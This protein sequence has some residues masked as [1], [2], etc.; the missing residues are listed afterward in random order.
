MSRL[1]EQ[2]T[3]QFHQWELR[4]RG[5]QMFDEPVSPEPPFRPFHG[6]YLPGAPAIDDGR[7]ATFL[8]SLVQKL[9]GKLSTE[10][11]LASVESEPE[12]E[13]EPQSLVR[14]ELIEFQASLPD[15]L[16]IHKEAFEQFLLSLS[17]CREPIAFEL[18][19]K[20]NK[21]TAQ[22]AAAAYDAP[23]LRRQLQAHFPDAQ[24]REQEGTLEKAW[25]A[26]DGNEA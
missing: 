9:S 22:F 25:L 3:E 18:L 14:E 17:L 15:K 7:K 19:G 2:L 4:G 1:D 21:V 24:F 23:L 5:W 11:P 20:P 6:H 8:S 26:S 16:D 10:T 13:P 12:E